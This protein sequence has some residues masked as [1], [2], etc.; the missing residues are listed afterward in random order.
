MLYMRKKRQAKKCLILLVNIWGFIK[1]KEWNFGKTFVWWKST[2]KINIVEI[3]DH[4]V[5]GIVSFD[6]DDSAMP[7][8][9][10]FLSNSL[11]C[12][13]QGLTPYS[14]TCFL[15]HWTEL[16]KVYEILICPML[17]WTEVGPC[18][19]L[20]TTFICMSSTWKFPQVHG[21]PQFL[22][23]IEWLLK[24]SI[25]YKRC[26][27]PFVI[28]IQLRYLWGQCSTYNAILFDRIEVMTLEI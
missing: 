16:Q 6:I 2:C 8:H 3:D 11:H 23:L 1:N 27:V 19:N 13:E 20:K 17:P 18:R 21:Q 9:S 7:L 25:H 14:L 10:P 26:A 15:L 24:Q 12:T 28:L 4:M 5:N 22:L